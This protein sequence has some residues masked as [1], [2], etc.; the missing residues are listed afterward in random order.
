MHRLTSLVTLE[1]DA[2]DGLGVPLAVL[3]LSTADLMRF[4][5]ATEQKSI[6][7]NT[8]K[9]S[10]QYSYPYLHE[11][12]HHWALFTLIHSLTA[13][14]QLMLMGEENVGKTSL[15]RFLLSDAL[16]DSAVPNVSTNGIS[17]SEWS[18]TNELQRSWRAFCPSCFEYLGGSD[19]PAATTTLSGMLWVCVL[20]YMSL[21]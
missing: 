7:W 14:S 17:I 3:R 13:G 11:H 4:L 6:R 2:S 18:G 5:R 16:I 15:T 12:V 10:Q 21:C 19:M 8:A 20:C 9:V 1:L